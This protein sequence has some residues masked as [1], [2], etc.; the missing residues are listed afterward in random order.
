MRGRCMLSLAT[1]CCLHVQQADPLA[2]DATLAADEASTIVNR[3]SA[4]GAMRR[5][6]LSALLSDATE[7]TGSHPA[8]EN[9]MA[10]LQLE[11]RRELAASGSSSAAVSF[12]SSSGSA[13][14]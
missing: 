2:T 3:L 11:S 6:V 13:S 1:I 9:V 5:A 12:N 7:F 14:G 4:D 10:L 8:D